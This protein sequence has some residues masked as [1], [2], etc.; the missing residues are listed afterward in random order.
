[1]NTPKSAIQLHVSHPVFWVVSTWNLSKNHLNLL[2]LRTTK[3]FSKR[4]KGYDS[5]YD[6]SLKIN[7][8][9]ET[10]NVEN[11]T[12]DIQ[13]KLHDVIQQGLHFLEMLT[14]LHLKL[15]NFETLAQCFHSET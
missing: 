9:K 11:K 12:N 15:G 8:L 10:V 14:E 13:S 6:S 1:M 2:Q 4:S 3:K 5:K 7:L